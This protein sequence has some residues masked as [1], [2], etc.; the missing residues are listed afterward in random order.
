[1]NIHLV[2]FASI[3][4]E[5]LLTLEKLKEWLT[6]FKPKAQDWIVFP[7]MWPSSFNPQEFK[8]QEVENAFCF[9]WLKKYAR[10]NQCY[11][12]GSML[13]IPHKGIQKKDIKQAYNSTYLIDPQGK[14]I[15]RY[16][17]IHLFTL[18]QE[19]EKFIPGHHIRTVR[20]PWGKIGLAICFDLRFPELFRA[21]SKRGAQLIIIPSAWPK[22]RID[23]WLTLLK[24]RAIENQC[25]VAGVNKVGKDSHGLTLGGHS[26]IFGPW[27]ESVALLKNRPG[28]CSVEINFEEVQKIRKQYPFL[29]SRVF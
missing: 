4:G 13:E 23:H 26:A 28:I 6:A 1:M 8:K 24:A 25:F 5:P 9:H 7:E 2:Q 10:D 17:K 21:H 14:L 3:D 29:K 15:T 22:I 20:F 18:G 16:R 27:G 12:T 11:M 19:H